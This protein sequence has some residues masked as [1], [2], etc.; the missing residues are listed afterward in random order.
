MPVP[1]RK[2]I[3]KNDYEA[4]KTESKGDRV[5]DTTKRRSLFFNEVGFQPGRHTSNIT[6]VMSGTSRPC[7]IWCNF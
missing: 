5:R 4:H 3:S 6:V 7:S 1:G 2:I